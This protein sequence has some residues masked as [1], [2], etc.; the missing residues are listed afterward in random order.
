MRGAGSV[1]VGAGVGVVDVDRILDLERCWC[2][3]AATADARRRRRHGGTAARQ[4]S[5][6]TA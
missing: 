1:I 2:S 3:R 5:G 6:M 4:T